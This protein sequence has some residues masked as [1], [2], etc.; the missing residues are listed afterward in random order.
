[1]VI[2]RD[3]TIIWIKAWLFL[4]LGVIASVLVVLE[5]P[6]VKIVLLLLLAIWA[7]CRVYYFAVLCHST[8]R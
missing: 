7:F 5:A 1:M 8:L 3:P 4:L 6:S 2:S